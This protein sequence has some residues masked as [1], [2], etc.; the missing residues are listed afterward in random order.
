LA[1]QLH[2]VSSLLILSVGL[3]WSADTRVFSHR[4]H[5]AQKLE[6]LSCHGSAASSTAVTDNNLPGPQVC[7]GC[8]TGAE[9]KPAKL[10]DFRVKSPRP[11]NLV[12]FNHQ[13]H[14]KLG[15]I[16]PLLARAIDTKSYLSPP[17]DIRQHLNTKNACAACHRGLQTSESVTAAAFPQMADCLVCHNTIDPPFSCSKCHSE[18]ASLKPVTHTPDWIDRHS[19]GKANL[20]KPSCAVCH[21]RRFTCL[22]C[23]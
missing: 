19:S 12:N 8:H 6:C 7:A 14:A 10:D 22:G 16:A 11:N 4:T 3:A 1:H 15:N 9:G 5:L 2:T 23:H 17:G 20:D 18:K 13:L 21:G